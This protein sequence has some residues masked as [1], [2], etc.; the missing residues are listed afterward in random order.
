MWSNL[1][2]LRKQWLLVQKE[3]SVKKLSAFFYKFSNG[4]VTIAAA[5]IFVLFTLLILPRFSQQVEQYS[6][7]MGSPDTSLFYTGAQLYSMAEAYGSEGRQ[8]FIEIRWT[9]DLAFPVI[10]SLFLVTSSSWLMRKI[11][12]VSSKWRLL[13]LVPLSAFFFDLAENSASS[14]VMW[15]YP[16]HCVIAQFMAPI[17]TPIKWLSVLAAFVLLIFVIVFWFVS[18]LRKKSISN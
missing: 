15:R 14:L 3:N 11:I 13:N 2:H 8:A 17:F 9:M 4:W 18:L 5:V 1:S 10:Y 7:G 6:Q 16:Q 12:P